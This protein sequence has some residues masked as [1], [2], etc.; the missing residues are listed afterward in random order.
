M[1][2]AAGQ[3]ASH[4]QEGEVGSRVLRESLDSLPCEWL[5]LLRGK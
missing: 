3:T 2:G 4:T 1:P 5:W